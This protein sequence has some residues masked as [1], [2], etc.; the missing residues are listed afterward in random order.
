MSMQFP[1]GYVEKM[2]LDRLRALPANVLERTEKYGAQFFT[3]RLAQIDRAEASHQPVLVYFI[4]AGRGHVKIG[5]SRRPEARL[6]QL[7]T[8][9]PERLILIGTMPGGRALET[10]L[11]AK[12]HR[13]AVGGEWFR[14]KGWL[15]HFIL[16][17]FG[18]AP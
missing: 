12:Y 6:K 10:E 3:G 1:D 9:Q 5:S 14:H 13:Y 7:Q 11:Q 8:A 2:S 4:G 18:A 17:R 16:R 15:R